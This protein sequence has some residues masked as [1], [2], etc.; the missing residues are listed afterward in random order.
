MRVA[1]DSADV[2]APLLTIVRLLT[3]RNV[4]RDVASSVA[5]P[6]R[7]SSHVLYAMYEIL[8]AILD[9]HPPVSGVLISAG[10]CGNTEPSLLTPYGESARGSKC[11]QATHHRPRLLSLVVGIDRLEYEQRGPA[12]CVPN[13]GKSEHVD[14]MT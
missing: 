3:F 6:T 7:P 12:S 13:G 8:G 4:G 1:I 11:E 9:A 2:R 10:G 14:D 5:P